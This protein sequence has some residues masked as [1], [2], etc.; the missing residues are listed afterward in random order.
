MT[1]WAFFKVIRKSRERRKQNEASLHWRR[2]KKGLGNQCQAACTQ[3]LPRKV[4]RCS[5]FQFSP[6]FKLALEL[7]AVME[8]YFRAGVTLTIGLP[9]SK[10]GMLWTLGSCFGALEHVKRCL[11]L[12]W[13][14]DHL[15]AGRQ[16]SQANPSSKAAETPGFYIRNM[17]SSLSRAWQSMLLLD[18]FITYCLGYVW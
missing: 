17:K 6:P 5:P 13:Q 8:I 15:H 11:G 14:L 16:M 3:K 9:G 2:P 12:H 1:K 10:P 7:W 18:S 4:E